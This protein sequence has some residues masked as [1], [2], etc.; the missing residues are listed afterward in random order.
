M[1]SFSERPIILHLLEMGFC[2]VWGYSL[3]LYRFKSG[4]KFHLNVKFTL[5][6]VLVLNFTITRVTTLVD[7]IS[8]I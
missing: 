3:S 8:G 6:K 7:V 5:V 2:F 1:T 4:L